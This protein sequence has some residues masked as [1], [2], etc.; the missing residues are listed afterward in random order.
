MSGAR[1]MTTALTTRAI[2]RHAER[3]ATLIE[4]LVA[5]AIFSFG[6]LAI[7]GM[8]ATHMTTASDAR[9][10][11]EAAQYAE[12]I[13]ADMRVTD[14]AVRAS[15]FAEGGT[16]FNLWKGRITGTGGLPLA[17]TTEQPLS[18]DFGAEAVT[19]TIRWRASTDRETDP[20]RY[21][22]TTFIE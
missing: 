13:L 9:Y 22:T 10:R 11:T 14:S 15:Q 21:A 12:S 4:G 8:L 18:I 1:P 5:I 6:M 3:G 19:V 16:K 2:R 17:G 7:V 20:H